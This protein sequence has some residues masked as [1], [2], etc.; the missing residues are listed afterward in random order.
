MTWNS[1]LSPTGRRRR[2]GLTLAG[3]VLVIVLLV[4]LVVA[5]VVAHHVSAPP[6]ASTTGPRPSMTMPMPTNAG[7]WDVAAENSLASRPMLWLPAEAAQPQTLTTA[8]AGPPITLPP[9][10]KTHGQWIPGGFPDTPAG[11]L[12]QLAALDTTSVAAGDPQV[13]AWG[14]RQ[15]SL[16]GAPDPGSTGL[17]SL[18]TSF[19]AHAGLANTGSVAG[20]TVSYQIDEGQIKGTTDGGRY[21]VVCA[22]GEF[23]ANY[24]GQVV[25][26]GVG[27]CQAMR[28]TG[29]AWRIAPGASAAPAS[30]AWPG[31]ADAVAAGYVGLS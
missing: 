25:S 4:A 26:A 3:L 21:A 7:G 16:P 5:L 28:W 30:C 19:R 29:M 11:A 10:T 18:L 15:W 13:Y 27:D 14:Y 12:A 24:Q 31:S 2:A 9:P 22:L 20:L 6:S 1:H 17:Y 8:T 23:S